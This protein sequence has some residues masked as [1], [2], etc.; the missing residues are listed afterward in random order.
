MLAATEDLET[1]EKLENLILETEQLIAANYETGFLA[2]GEARGGYATIISAAIS[3]F[4]IKGYKLAAELLTHMSQNKAL[5]SDYYPV[6]GYRVMSSDFTYQILMS[7]FKPELVAYLKDGTTNGDDLYYAIHKFNYTVSSYNNRTLF[8]DD[9]YDYGKEDYGG[10]EEF[11][12]NELVKAQEAGE[13]I[14]FYTKITVNAE[15]YLRVENLGKNGSAWNIKISNYGSKEETVI[16]NQKMCNGGDAANWTGLKDIA[17]V[18]LPANGGSAVVTISE[19]AFATH[20]AICKTSG[21]YRYITYANDLSASREISQCVDT[22]ACKDYGAVNLLG[23][24]GGNWLVKVTNKGNSFATVEYND[25]MCFES[26]AVNWK[27]LS[28]LHSFGLKGGKSEVISI[29]ENAFATHIAVSF[30]NSDSRYIYYANQ[31]DINCSMNLNT[32]ILYNNLQLSIARKSGSTWY[33]NIKNP[34]NTRLY[35]AY[36]AKMCNRGDAANWTGLKNVNYVSIPKGETV[37]VAI[38]E[39]WF[40]T[41]IAVSY[42]KYGKRVISYADGLN[43]N[44]S[45]NVYYN[46]I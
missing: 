22:I 5:D 18:N 13:L 32:K 39:N 28:N 16:Y 33:I 20:V 12:I 35:V 19:N 26:D 27:G 36:N 17:Y 34:T 23:K 37:Q 43:K 40:A 25:K 11:V 6:Y 46:Q 41:S 15:K 45:I 1:K 38:K 3:Y 8:I 9:R 7:K 4:K 24:N 2:D 44:G 14:P 30:K 29:S 21:L 31:L 42:E 10:L